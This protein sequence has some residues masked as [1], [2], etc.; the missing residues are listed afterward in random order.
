MAKTD[1]KSELNTQCS[2]VVGERFRCTAKWAEFIFRPTPPVPDTHVLYWPGMRRLLE[3]FRVHGRHEELS[4]FTIGRHRYW[5][6]DVV[7]M[8]DPISDDYFHEHLLK[9]GYVDHVL[10]PPPIIVAVDLDEVLGEFVAPLVQF[11]RKSDPS[12]F[13]K[14]AVDDFN[15]YHFASI[16]KLPEAETQAWV[17]RFYESSFFENPKPLIDALQV[18][19]VL[20]STGR[21][22]FHVVTSRLSKLELVTK[23]WLLRHYPGVFEDVHLGNHYDRSPKSIQRKKSE[24][25]RSIGAQWLIDDSWTYAVDAAEAGLSVILFGNYPWN[26][27][28]PTTASSLLHRITRCTDWKQVEKLLTHSNTSASHQIHSISSTPGCW[29]SSFRPERVTRLSISFL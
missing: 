5:E 7:P 27:H 3:A 11:L 22:R 29:W 20:H 23:Q 19:G 10:L 25:C 14:L 1:V 13:G 24:M 4:S 17:E 12:S 15:Q 18:F 9:P 21:F 28:S 2:G 26:K 6:C 8:L 16:L